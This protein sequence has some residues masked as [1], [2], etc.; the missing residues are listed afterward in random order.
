[1]SIAEQLMCHD[2]RPLVRQRA[3]ALPGTQSAMDRK[4]CRDPPTAWGNTPFAEVRAAP[5]IAATM[6]PHPARRHVSKRAVVGGYAL[7]RSAA[8][9]GPPAITLYADS[10]NPVFGCHGE[11]EG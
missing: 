8:W 1:M 6:P 2:A 7:G 4:T 9:G 10:D 5:R 11:A 3:F